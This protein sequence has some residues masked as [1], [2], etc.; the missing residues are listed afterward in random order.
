MSKRKHDEDESESDSASESTPQDMQECV[1][2]PSTGSLLNICIQL[3]RDNF[4]MHRLRFPINNYMEGFLR[5]F[6]R[7]PGTHL[8]SRPIVVNAAILLM[9]CARFFGSRVELVVMMVKKRARFDSSV[10][11]RPFMWSFLPKGYRRKVDDTRLRRVDSSQSVSSCSD[12]Q[13]LVAIEPE[14]NDQSDCEANIEVETILNPIVPNASPQDLEERAA[15]LRKRLDE[16]CSSEMASKLQKEL[17]EVLMRLPYT[18]EGII[19]DLDK[20]YTVSELGSVFSSVGS[21]PRVEE[22]T[23]TNDKDGEKLVRPKRKLQD[24]DEYFD[25]DQLKKKQHCWFEEVNYSW[26]TGQNGV[27]IYPEEDQNNDQENDENQ[28]DDASSGGLDITC[29]NDSGIIITDITD[30]SADN[31]ASMNLDNMMA[32]EEQNN[33]AC[34]EEIIL[35]ECQNNDGETTIPNVIE[36]EPSSSG[37]S[38]FF[39]AALTLAGEQKVKIQDNGEQGKA[40]TVEQLGAELSRQP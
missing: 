19:Y 40:T 26:E 20:E 38:Q 1:V 32:A 23:A 21:E 39:M 9:Q 2:S 10:S 6:L 5:C 16:P 12:V 28:S 35:T 31:D 7:L 18:P 17:N 11:L 27:V 15:E 36:N 24:L 25:S 13:P 14:T 33:V 22:E 4:L 37:V 30:I 34:C 8:L 29:T 3:S